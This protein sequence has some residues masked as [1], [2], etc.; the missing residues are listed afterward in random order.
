MMPAA[1]ASMP[2]SRKVSEIVVSTLMPMR[3]AASGSCA[4]ARMA[5]PS[6]LPWMNAVI[7][8]SSGIVTKIES[9]SPLVKSMPAMSNSACCEFDE[10]G[11]A[12]LRAAAPQQPDVLEDEREADRR[13]Q[14]RQLRGAMRNGR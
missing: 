4:V 5:L 3:R 2:P 9:R 10:V 6:R 12:L 11:D 8:S 13:D 7:A 14:R 1:P